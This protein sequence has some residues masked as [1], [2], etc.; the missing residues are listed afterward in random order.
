[1]APHGIDEPFPGDKVAV[2]SGNGNENG[3]DASLH[4]FYRAS[5]CPTP[6]LPRKDLRIPSRHPAGSNALPFDF[7]APNAP[8]LPANDKRFAQPML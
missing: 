4:P 7:T 3:H 2:T 5:F 1:L 8:P 6:L